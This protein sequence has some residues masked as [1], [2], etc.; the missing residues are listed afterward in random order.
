M[1]LIAA[2]HPAKRREWYSHF[3]G[4]V[5]RSLGELGAVVSNPLMLGRLPLKCLLVFVPLILGLITLPAFPGV[6]AGEDTTNMLQRLPVSRW[7]FGIYRLETDIQITQWPNFPALTHGDVAV[8]VVTAPV[9]PHR[10]LGIVISF[11]PGQDPDQD[12]SEDYCK[13]AIQAV[14]ARG[15]IVDGKL[16]PA[17]TASGNGSYYAGFFSPSLT[18][19]VAGPKAYGAQV[20]RLISIEIKMLG[21]FCRGPL[22]STTVVSSK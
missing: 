14:R 13:R 21:G 1:S 15:G 19:G 18:S 9:P 6:R 12:F 8:H 2:P 10:P 22:M 7:D 4:L 11:T 20:D 5:L 17:M 16:P 3:E